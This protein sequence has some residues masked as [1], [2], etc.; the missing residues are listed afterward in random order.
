MHITAAAERS[1]LSV[2]TIRYYEKEG[3][4]PPVQRDGRGWRQYTADTLD[5][6]VTLQRLQATGMPMADMVRFA[7]SA[8]GPN[9]E[10]RAEQQ[11]RRDLLKSHAARLARNQAELD[12]CA[13]DLAGT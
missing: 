9:A 13:A 10:V 2:D 1:G 4:D 7:R 8:H 3:L 6:L 5:W 11:L 12:A